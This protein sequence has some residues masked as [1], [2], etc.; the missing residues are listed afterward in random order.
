[1]FNIFKKSSS[2]D[3]QMTK[4]AVL[5]LANK[6]RDEGYE[7]FYFELRAYHSSQGNTAAYNATNQKI[8]TINTLIDES[9]Q[10]IANNYGLNNKKIQEMVY[11][12]TV[13]ALRNLEDSKKMAVD[14]ELPFISHII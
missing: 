11:V 9:L 6:W 2:Q 4:E 10:A 14:M 8:Q 3:I 13:T 12:R 7:K 1:M 5:E